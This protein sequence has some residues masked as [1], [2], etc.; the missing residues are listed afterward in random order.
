MFREVMYIND[1]KWQLTTYKIQ[2]N[3][4]VYEEQR[5]TRKKNKKK[6]PEKNLMM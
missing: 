3:V 4:H 1:N 5:Y 6:K 2:N